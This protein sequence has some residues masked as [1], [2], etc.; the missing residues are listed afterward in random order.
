VLPGEYDWF[1]NENKTRIPAAAIWVFFDFLL[2]IWWGMYHIYEGLNGTGIYPPL[3][4]KNLFH[5]YDIA[6]FIS[7]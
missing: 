1:F 6:V 4:K 5:Q 7:F 3:N 2:K